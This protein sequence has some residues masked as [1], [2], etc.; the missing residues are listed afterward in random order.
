MVFLAI[1]DAN[2]ILETTLVSR[3][4][5]YICEFEIALVTM[6]RGSTRLADGPHCSALITDCNC[7]EDIFDI[8]I[9]VRL[10]ILDMIFKEFMKT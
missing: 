1:C 10:L 3:N 7:Y 9:F 2:H 8:L 6:G 4:G 5:L